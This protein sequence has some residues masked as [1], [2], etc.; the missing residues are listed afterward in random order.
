MKRTTSSIG[1]YLLLVALACIGMVIYVWLQ[2]TVSN[3]VQKLSQLANERR[4]LTDENNRLQAEIMRLSNSDRI[5]QVASEKLG[6]VV[7][8]TRPIELHAKR[9][10]SSR[11]RWER[12][13]AVFSK[14]ASFFRRLVLG[15][16]PEPTKSSGPPQ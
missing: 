9:L 12:F 11:T 15:S 2:L 8:T 13:I 5:V 16:S 4:I 7:P 6:M 1:K 14:S 3:L 10:Y